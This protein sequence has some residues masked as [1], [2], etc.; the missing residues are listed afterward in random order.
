VIDPARGDL[1]VEDLH[2]FSADYARTLNAWAENF[3][4]AWPSL[5]DTYGE[6]FRRM[7]LYY[8]NG[9]EALFTA[10]MV[11][12]YQIVYSKGGIPGG[13]TAVR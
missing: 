12:L 5:K 8:L 1:V 10:R 6:S 4:D 2:N 3:E 13:Y 7:W 9:C 11:Q